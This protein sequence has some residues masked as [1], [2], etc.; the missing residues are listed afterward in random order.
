MWHS[1]YLTIQLTSISASNTWDFQISTSW[2]TFHIVSLS[3]FSNCSGEAWIVETH[4]GVIC[5]LWGLMTLNII[6]VLFGHLNRDVFK[7]VTV[8][9]ISFVFFL[10]FKFIFIHLSFFCYL[11]SHPWHMEFPR[12]WVELE[13][14][15]PAYAAAT[16]K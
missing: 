5:I 9:I 4:Y 12:L 1:S 10:I 14:Q 7:S 8:L 11:G 15:L 13:L 3:N 6:S 2:P 16:A